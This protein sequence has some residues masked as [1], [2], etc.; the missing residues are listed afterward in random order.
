MLT[1]GVEDPLERAKIVYKFMQDKTRYISVQVGI[2]GWKPMDA[3]DVDKL[4]Y[5]DCKGLTNYT[6]ALLDAVDVPSYYTVVWGD[7]EI[8]NIDKDF[9][10]T[11]GNHVILC[12]PNNDENIFLECT[13]QTVPFGY[14]A[15]FTDDR[16][17]LLVTPEGGK[18][19]HTKTYTAKDNLQQTT[20]EI[21]ITEEGNISADVTMVSE[22]I[23]YRQHN[24]I[25]TKK[26]KDQKLVYMQDYWDDINEMEIKDIKLTNNK[27]KV[28]FTEAVKFTASNYGKISA[29][30]LIFKPNILDKSTYI[31]RKNSNRK[32]DIKVYRGTTSIADYK[33]KIPEN[34]IVEALPKPVEISTKFGIYKFKVT[35]AEDQQLHVKRELILNK[36]TF[37]AADYNEFRNF[38]KAIVKSDRTKVVLKFQ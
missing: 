37:A 35:Q 10:V 3:M 33:L 5:A 30:R 28:Q 16:D 25:A 13:S 15:G 27:E 23:R 9:S 31:P 14:T 22:G 12:L 29:K 8:K 6:K 26:L 20:A 24:G 19:V 32:S 17:V 34:T 11:E 1:D 36:G 7:S 4:G 38:K 2:G 18:I 21:A